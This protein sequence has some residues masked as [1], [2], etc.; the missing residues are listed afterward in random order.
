MGHGG[1][2]LIAKSQTTFHGVEQ[3]SYTATVST[4]P[5]PFIGGLPVFFQENPK[6]LQKC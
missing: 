2:K 5:P 4:S 1:E 3:K 6:I